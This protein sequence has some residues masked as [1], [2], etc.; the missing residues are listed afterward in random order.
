MPDIPNP[1]E[2]IGKSVG[3]AAASVAGDVLDT[4]G[5]KVWNFSTSLFAAAFSLVDRFTAPDVDPRSGALG[6]VLPVTLWVGGVALLLLAFV[7]LGK[8]LV[9][10]GRG[11]GTL[12]IG[13]AQYS[14]ITTGGLTLLSTL[15]AASDGLAIGLLTAG[16]HVDS[17]TALAD[18]YSVWQKAAPTAGGVAM[19]LI[20]LICVIPA[21]FGLLIEALIRHAAILVL[22]ATIP[23]LAAGLVL[24]ST[25]RWF[26]TGLRWMVALLLLTP[27]IALVTV[28]GLQAAAGAAKGLAQ[29][30]NAGTALV[31]LVVGGVLLLVATLCPLVLFKLLAFLD[32]NTVS[33]GAVRG[34]LSSSGGQQAASPAAAAQL[35]QSGG[36]GGEDATES[37][38]GSQLAPSLGQFGKVADAASER[39][40]QILDTAGVGHYG[41]ATA[42]DGRNNGRSNDRSAHDPNRSPAEDDTPPPPSGSPGTSSDGASEPLPVPAPNRGASRRSG[43]APAGRTKHPAPSLHGLGAA[44][45]SRVRPA[46]RSRRRGCLPCDRPAQRLRPPDVRGMAPRTARRLRRPDRCAGLPGR[47]ARPATAGGDGPVPLAPGRRT[48]PGHR[49]RDGV[50]RHPGAGSAGGA[51][52]GGPGPVP[53]GAGDRVEPVAV[54]RV[55]RCRNPGGAGAARPSRGDRRAPD[56]RRTAVRAVGQ[57]GLPAAGPALRPLVGTAKLAH[58]GVAAVDETTRDGYA[59]ELGNLLAA[60]ADSEQVAGLSLLIRTVPDDGAERAAW[61][62]DHEASDAPALVVR[63]ARQLE[64]SIVAASVRHEVFLTVSVSEAKVRR[65]ARDAGGGAVG[66]A[67]VLYRYLGEL[68]Q[69]LRAIGVTDLTW[70]TST[71]VATTIRTGYNLADAAG[72]ARAA[73]ASR[74]GLRVETGTLPG[75]AG[76]ATA[77]S[78]AS[79]AYEHDAY[80]TVSYALLLP[81]RPTTVGALARLLAPASPGER[82]CLA[83][84]YEPLPPSRADRQIDRNTWAAEIAVDVKAKRGFRVPRRDRK[85]LA[86][87]AEQERQL[88]RG[89]S[90]V[91]VAGAAAVTVPTTAGVED[92]AAGLEGSARAA[93]F[94]LLRLDLA[95]DSGFVAAVLPLGIGLP[96]RGE[97]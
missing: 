46:P 53:S 72:L 45:Q 11:F 78:P 48:V 9:A 64:A 81:K 93:G 19:G 44:R 74:R 23:I 77:P 55:D 33:G 15:V 58:P 1:I 43:R 52:A 36:S 79:R 20:A 18:Q 41:V 91:R 24:E 70:L 86:D 28:I 83:L 63:T 49:A 54:D 39:G 60:A 7:Q 25:T 82:R 88:A 37:R 17:F 75:A 85:R 26:W 59:T 90:L 31:S 30:D 89:H 87:V 4:V 22:A 94:Q 38:F 76:P 56:A 51:V 8:V 47:P 3:G 32:P 97:R 42:Q 14:L 66:R 57:P 73:H 35:E 92:A 67:R 95:Q 61:V 96:K 2:V 27:A 16:S 40:G 62:A 5:E 34:F 13:L 71:E 50:G 80:T 6:G 84:H 29:P 12:V 68:E 21:A 69:R 10:G 65:A